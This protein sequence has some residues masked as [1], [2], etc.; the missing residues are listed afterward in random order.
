MQTNVD[1]NQGCFLFPP[2]VTG[3][4]GTDLLLDAANE[5]A[6]FV[7]Q[8]PKTGSINKISFSTGTVT[9]GETVDVRVE[10][11]T[12]ATGFPSGSL[13]AANNNIAHI[14]ANSDDNVALTTAS[15]TAAAAV[16]MG[17]VIAVVIAMPGA[18]AA[19]LNIRAG[20]V[21][22]E[23]TAGFPYYCHFTA[24]WAK[25]NLTSP[26]V[27]LLYTDGYY[28]STP[29]THL[30]GGNTFSANLSTANPI[31]GGARFK[32]PYALEV[33]GMYWYGAVNIDSN[34]YAAKLYDPSDALITSVTMEGSYAGTTGSNFHQVLFTTPV[35]IPPYQWHRV[36]LEGLTAGN[37]TIRFWD[38][39]SAAQMDLFP[40]GQNFHY[41]TW[42]GAAWSDTVTRRPQMGLIA[43]AI[44]SAPKLRRLSRGARY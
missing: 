29:G 17:Q 43:R 23:Q 8:A 32:L 42:T 1:S 19:S 39:A 12:A 16:T 2:P 18:T 31:R 35:I 9:T 10:S 41:T 11:V 30:I 38:V 20:A 26:A 5:K 4:A 37:T 34:D 3:T 6:G 21:R 25:N 22:N 40:L 13:L 15:L 24:A 27:G 36:V 44:D 28:Y 33:I 7:L 14:I